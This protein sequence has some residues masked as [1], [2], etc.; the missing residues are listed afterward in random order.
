MRINPWKLFTG[1]FIPTWLATREEIS[2]GAKIIYA[3]LAQ[4]AGKK[5]SCFPKQTTLA[6]EVGMSRRNIIRSI[7]ELRDSSL[8]ELERTGARKPN[9]YFFLAHKWMGE[10]PSWHITENSEVPTGHA[11]TPGEVTEPAHH[12]IRDSKRLKDSVEAPAARDTNTTRAKEWI[13]WY[14]G[15]YETEMKDR[16]QVRWD[17]DTI[18]VK[19]LLELHGFTE[20]M[21]RAD[22]Y[23]A[24]DDPFLAKTGYTITLFSA[25]WNSYS[26]EME[27]RR[28]QRRKL[29]PGPITPKPW[30]CDQCGA[31]MPE[32]KQWNHTS[33]TAC[34]AWK[35]AA[36]IDQDMIGEAIGGL[37]QTLRSPERRRR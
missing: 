23:L 16:Y 36:T 24:D 31:T 8:I 25:R 4:Y 28:D 11:T 14:A 17:R 29:T 2:P 34:P 32:T 6:D 15:R 19:R 26:P 22:R 18:A 7:K 21:R 13:L 20:L 37:Q 35:P 5:G 12:T 10:V 1:C 30:T 27:R 33:T 3:R 9:R